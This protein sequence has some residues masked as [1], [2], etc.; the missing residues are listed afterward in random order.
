M[1]EKII[2]ATDL[3][4]EDDAPVTTALEIAKLNHGKLYILHVLESASSQ[5]RHLVKHFRTGKELESNPHYEREVLDSMTDTYAA[6]LDSYQNYEINV[7]TGY[8]YEEI[9]SRARKT[10]A[11]L[12]V[13]GPHSTRAREKGVVRVKGKVGTTAQGIIMNECCPVMIVNQHFSLEKLQFKNLIIGM[14]FSKSCMGAFRYALKLAAVYGSKIF[15]YTMLPV[16]PSSQ[17]TQTMYQSDLKI[18]QGKLDT[19]CQEIPPHIHAECQAWGGVHPH[20]E[21]LKYAAKKEA[22]TI[23]MGSHTKDNAGKWYVG[24]AVER[25]SYRAAGPII[26][27]TGPAT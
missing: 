12:I 9:L 5:N 18:A 2:S 15:V 6:H 25:V 20:L 14:D 19:V 21:I 16:P 1:F 17:Y 11:D 22:D 27:V 23:V 10:A 24:S 8:P 13:I 26:V 3:V 7:T 4:G